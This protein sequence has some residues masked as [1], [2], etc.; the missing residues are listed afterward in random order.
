ML[1]LK[2]SRTGKKK[3]P[4]FR[5]VVM[6]QQKDPWGNSLEIV[7]NYNPRTKVYNLQNERIQYWLSKGAQPTDTVH[8]LF[9]TAGILKGPKKTVSKLTKAIRA[10]MAKEK[11]EKE[12]P[13]EEK[14]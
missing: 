9:V 1:R 12:K 2:Y 4:Y 5:I 10:K 7:G 3:Q 11:A 13:K 14:K 8:N 6:E